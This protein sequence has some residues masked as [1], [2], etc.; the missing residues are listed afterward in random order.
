MRRTVILAA[1]GA[2]VLSSPAFAGDGVLAR[3]RSRTVAA[4]HQAA[5]LAR[6]AADRTGRLATVAWRESAGAVEGAWARTR[7]GVS[8]AAETVAEGVSAARDRVCERAC[9]MA[10]AAAPRR[11]VFLLKTPLEAAHDGTALDSWVALEPGTRLPARV[12]LLVHGLD[13]PGSVWAEMAPALQREGYAVARLDYL[14]DQALADSA[15]ALDGS[16]GQLAS[17]GVERVDL[18]CH[19][20]GGLIALDVLTRNGMYAGEPAREGRP[21]IGRLVTLGTPARG[22]WWAHFAPVADATEHVQRWWHSDAMDP[23]LLLGFLCDGDGGAATDLLPGSAYLAGLASRPAPHVPV[24]AV[25]GVIAAVDE[26]DLDAL[27]RCAVV[28]WVA[29]EGG[30]DAAATGLKSAFQ[31]LGDGVVST[32]SAAIPGAEVV[33]APADHRSLVRTIGAEEA[34]RRLIGSPQEMPPG[35][36]VTLRTLAEE[37]AMR[38]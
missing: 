27:K 8:D 22:S 2:G 23:R 21:R 19:S 31:W 34:L 28:R 18:V 3:A 35:I 14:N 10:E 16:L 37:P 30:V 7:D 15:A 17:A 1:I 5:G 9:A 38:R 25:V 6:A 13:E 12:V 32:R 4:C 29:G 36:A 11:G 33:T 24:T 26:R 20:M